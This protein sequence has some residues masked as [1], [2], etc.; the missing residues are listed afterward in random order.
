MIYKSSRAAGTITI[1]KKTRLEER[2]RDAS[3]SK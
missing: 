1:G 3:G 2:E